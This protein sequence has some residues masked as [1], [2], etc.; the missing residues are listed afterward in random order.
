M[1]RH[2][3]ILIELD[4]G[5]IPS[6]QKQS[7]WLPKKPAWYKA[8]TVEM[9]KYKADMQGRL[10]SLAVPDTLGCSN[11]QCCDP[12]HSGDRDKFVLDIL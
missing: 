9:D 4:V 7:S 11:P 2:S 6:K 3:P 1:S 10:Q 5:A 12:E 8:T